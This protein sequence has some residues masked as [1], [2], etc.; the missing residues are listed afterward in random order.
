MVEEFFV[1]VIGIIPLVGEF[2]V[3]VIDI[4]PLVEDF[5]VVVMGIIVVEKVFNQ[6]NKS[7]VEWVIFPV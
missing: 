5:I 1:V 6:G 3:V 7:S 2:F 4:I